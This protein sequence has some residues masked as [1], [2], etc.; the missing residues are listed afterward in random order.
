MFGDEIRDIILRSV[1]GLA[2]GQSGVAV[3]V[4]SVALGAGLEDD[5]VRHGA[6]ILMRE[7]LTIPA[8]E[9]GCIVLSKAGVAA[10]K[11]ELEHRSDFVFA[12]GQ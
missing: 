8:H 9:A 3:K 10:A 11:A 12:D 1:Y 6:E 7:G 2:K 4:S 5:E